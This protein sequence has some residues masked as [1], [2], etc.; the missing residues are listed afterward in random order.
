MLEPGQQAF[1]KDIHRISPKYPTFQ[2]YL[3]NSL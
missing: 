1:S 3:R 2:K